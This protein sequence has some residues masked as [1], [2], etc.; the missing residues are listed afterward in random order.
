MTRTRDIDTSLRTLDAAQTGVDPTST[1]ARADLQ[2]ILATERSP[3]SPRHHPPAPRAT[4]RRVVFAGGILAAAAVG[5]VVLPAFTGGDQAF[6]TWTGDPGAL[7]PKERADAAESCRQ[8]QH[9]G[10]D[11]AAALD[12]AR[13]AIAERRG[14]WTTVVLAGADGFSAMCITD[15][16]THLFT[17]DLIGSIGT[18]G[19]YTAPASDDLVATDLGTGTMNAGDLS[20][21]AGYAG[22]DVVGVV[23]NSPTHGKVQA[24]VSEGRF[25][26]WLPGDELIDASATNPVEVEV[27][28]RDGSTRSRSLSL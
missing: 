8:E 27:T 6:A 15:D 12:N 20:L 19:D 3:S 13:P 16:S 17:K 7:T 18:P 10:D 14:V 21:A 5:A 2:R 9:D 28:L 1:R 23:Y 11:Y 25:A 24:S 26:L 4:A 22:S